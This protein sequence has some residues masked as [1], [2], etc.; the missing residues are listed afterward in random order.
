MDIT[1]GYGHY[2]RCERNRHCRSYGGYG[3]ITGGNVRH[4]AFAVL[5]VTKP[6]EYT[7]KSVLL[8]L[9]DK[10]MSHCSSS[11]QLLTVM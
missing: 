2:G 7:Q 1:D 3:Y 4:M 6:L 8:N 11:W 9:V 5:F 10:D